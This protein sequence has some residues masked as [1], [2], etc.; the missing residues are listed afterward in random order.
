MPK[1]RGFMLLDEN[2]VK[3]EMLFEKSLYMLKEQSSLKQ[4]LN[5]TITEINLD[6]FY[7]IFFVDEVILHKNIC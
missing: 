1:E 5:E 7:D 6:S 4:E 3:T 2:R